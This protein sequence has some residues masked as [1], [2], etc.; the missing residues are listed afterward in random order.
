MSHRWAPVRLALSTKVGAQLPLLA[1]L[2]PPA[3]LLDRVRARW[4]LRR[5]I[6][7]LTRSGLFDRNWY[8]ANHPDVAAAGMDPVR[9]YLLHG[10]YEG[11]DPGPDFDTR[12][13]LAEYQDVNRAGVNPLVHFLS[14]GKA[15]GRAP[16]PTAAWAA[17]RTGN[18]ANPVIPVD[19]GTRKQK[20]SFN[21]AE[22]LRHMGNNP[23]PPVVLVPVHNAAAEAEACVKSLLKHTGPRSRILVIDDASTDPNV[24]TMLDRYN[25]LGQIEVVRNEQ[26]LGFTRTINRGIA[27]AG[28]S[29]VVFLN[30]DTRVT[31]RW[32]LNLRIAAYSGERVGTATAFSNNAGAFSAPD[33]G[34]NNPLPSSVSL[35]DY[36]RAISQASLRVYPPVP[37]GNVFCMYVRRDCLDATGVLDEEAFPRGY[38]VENDF[39]MR[40]GRLGWSHVID[41]ATLI[42]HAR[43]ASFGD[44]SSDLARSARQVIDERYPEYSAAI[45]AFLRSEGVRAARERVRDVRAVI[46]PESRP[47][48]RVVFVISTTTGGTPHTNEDLMAAVGDRMQTFVLLCDSAKLS[49]LVFRDGTYITL[50]QHTLGKPLRAFPHRSDEYDAVLAEW[51]TRYAIELIHIRHIARHG[52]GLID[53]ADGLALPVVFSFHDFYAACPTVHLLDEENVYCGGRC[54]ATEGTCRYGLWGDRSLP[55]LKHAAISTLR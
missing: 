21:V 30:S 20:L 53:V 11:R 27:L 6:S 55:P 10:A 24:R 50:E 22:A 52:L 43:S 45:G 48:P 12:F 44:T 18:L 29:D 4:R 41:G 7:L 36:A 9:H 14:F 13:Y 35:D 23:E 19:L 25:G 16:C 40:A 8:L 47:K 5:E 26:N 51:L 37:T 17:K 28:R 2:Y 38:G 34:R 15:E 46:G 3:K 39:C 1:R 32:L 31:P 49:L 33:A 42:G 54:T